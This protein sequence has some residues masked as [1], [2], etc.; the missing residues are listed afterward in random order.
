MD[1]KQCMEYLTEI[2][3]PVLSSEM[4]DLCDRHITLNEI[5]TALNAML[6]NKIPGNDS[7]TKEFYLAFFDILGSRLL[8][9][10]NY[11]FLSVRS[12]LYKDRQ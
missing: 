5:F 9:C 4:K 10:L 2:N 1:E 11:A 7:L 8:K 6:S 12:Q 3:T